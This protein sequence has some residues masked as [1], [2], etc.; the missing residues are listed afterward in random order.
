M[1]CVGGASIKFVALVGF[2]ENLPSDQVH[3][4]TWTLSSD[5]KDWNEATPQS[6]TAL[7]ANPSFRAAGLPQLTPSFPVI[8]I[9]EPDVIYVILNDV[10]RQDIF[11]RVCAVD[12]KRKAHYV[13]RIDTVRMEVLDSTKVVPGSLPSQFP[14]PIA[15]EFSAHLQGSS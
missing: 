3:L 9:D 5:L 8:S 7:W 15:S 2:H 12:F 4:R 14:S 6:V 13:L 10:D 1:G 11:G